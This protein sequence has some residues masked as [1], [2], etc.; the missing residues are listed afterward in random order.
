MP[1]PPRR[2]LVSWSPRGL[3]P[4]SL[5]CAGEAS[6]SPRAGVPRSYLILASRAYPAKAMKVPEMKLVVISPLSSRRPRR[7]RGERPRP[8]IGPYA[9]PAGRCQPSNSR[10]RALHGRRNHGRL[11]W[12]HHRACSECT[13]AV[14]SVPPCALTRTS[15][16]DP[17]RGRAG[18]RRVQSPAERA[19][20]RPG[21]PRRR[22]LHHAL[23]REPGAHGLIDL[24]RLT[25][26]GRSLRVCVGPQ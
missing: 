25:R 8:A 2:A 11:G 7:P 22:S 20:A 26:V 19:A 17:R 14:R 18:P 3:L 16:F 13:V 10:L 6:G 1:G 12:H 24:A 21:S 23:G 4:I 9:R 5:R 15:Q